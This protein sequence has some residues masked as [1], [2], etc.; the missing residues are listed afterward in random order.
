LGRGCK[1]RWPKSRP[2]ETTLP[3]RE[4]GTPGGGAEEPMRKK[5]SSSFLIT[6][7]WCLH[8][9]KGSARN[10]TILKNQTLT[11]QII[12][13]EGVEYALKRYKEGRLSGR[14]P[15]VKG[16]G[17]THQSIY[18]LGLPWWGTK[19]GCR[20]LLFWGVPVGKTGNLPR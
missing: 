5:R 13:K 2:I 12:P 7:R 17:R 10:S 14:G 11:S 18:K 9:G 6:K 4:N 16:K 8:S 19:R 3:V 1:G 20:H 15:R